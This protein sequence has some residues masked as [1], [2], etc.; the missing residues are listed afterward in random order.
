MG[1]T[2]NA[3]LVKDLIERI[4]KS[5][6]S[7]GSWDHLEFLTA[8]SFG[9]LVASGMKCSDQR[10]LK[11]IEFF[12]RENPE[13][14]YFY[15]T[16]DDI[17]FPMLLE[18]LINSSYQGELLTAV[19]NDF[20]T[21]VIEFR[22]DMFDFAFYNAYLAGKLALEKQIVI[23]SVHLRQIQCEFDV[24]KYALE[25]KHKLLLSNYD[26]EIKKKVAESL[27][28]RQKDIKELKTKNKNIAQ[29]IFSMKKKSLYLKEE[30]EDMKKT[31][32][33]I[34]VGVFLIVLSIIFI[35]L[36]LFLL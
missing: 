19:I 14:G 5:Q 3:D 25:K 8:V 15:Y 4:T 12:N 28:D 7:D 30:I 18:G 33:V 9:A 24:E 36:I 11:T 17:G 29:N 26:D 10:I 35:G 21:A 31:N 27:Y 16:Y 32:S 2:Q 34:K 22:G 23:N 1:E 13:K 6:L 20:I